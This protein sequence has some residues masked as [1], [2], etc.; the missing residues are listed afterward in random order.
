[1]KTGWA[2]RWGPWE[3]LELGGRDTTSISDWWKAR[4]FIAIIWEVHLEFICLIVT[5]MALKTIGFASKFCYKCPSEIVVQQ[6]ILSKK[7][8]KVI[9]IHQL[10][11]MYLYVELY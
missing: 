6:F 1:M 3:R 8:I 11:I 7:S 5:E 10:Q 9:V 2:R 4:G